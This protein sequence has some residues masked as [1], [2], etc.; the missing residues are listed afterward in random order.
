MKQTTDNAPMPESCLASVSSCLFLVNSL[1]GTDKYIQSIFM[2][3][4][5]YQFHL[6]IKK[7]YPNAKP[8]IHK[9]KDHIITEIESEFLDINGI[10]SDIENYNE[11]S[12]NDFEAVE[13]WSFSRNKMIQISECSFCEEPI[14]V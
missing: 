8:L 4:G 9:N 12:E 14:V 3:G 13:K 1:R 6:F 5:C 11:L 7:L 2:Q 10:V